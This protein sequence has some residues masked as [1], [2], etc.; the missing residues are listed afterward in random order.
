MIFRKLFQ[1]ISA[2][3][4]LTA[5]AF[6]EER[7]GLQ[8]IIDGTLRNQELSDTPPSA[9]TSQ[10]NLNGQ[11]VLLGS[12]RLRDDLS[13][14]Y[15]GRVNHTEDLSGS[16]PRV[17][18]TRTNSVVQAYV[19]YS[20]RLPWDL[21]LQIGKF[22]TPF[23]QF[24]TRNYSNENPLIGFPLTYTHRTPIRADQFPKSPYYLVSPRSDESSSGYLG[25]TD[26]D[27]RLPLLNFSYPTG[28][29]AFGNPGKFDYRIALV[30]SSLAN[31]LDLGTPGQRV[32]WIAA[33]GI[34]CV[35][36]LHLGASFAEGPYLDA[37]VNS[38][39][40]LGTS[41]NEFKQRALGFDFQYAIHHLEAYGE[42][43]FNTFEVPNIPQR[44]GAT[45]YYLELK[46]TWTPRFFSAIRWNQ[47]YFDRLR[48]GLSSDFR[49]RFDNNVNSLEFGLGYR[50]TERLLA[51]GSYQHNQ[52]LGGRDP[53]NDVFA[54]Q[55]VYSL[56]IWNLLRGR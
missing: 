16:S 37:S 30:N 11:F 17:Q 12:L 40:P 22:G 41:F 50:L 3:L 32:Q 45:G 48:G 5:S 14:F 52:N 21:N 55:I 26:S 4:C 13:A 15:E 10:T 8:G 49:P 35:V 25:G 20:P 29:M 28:I 24:L 53:Y 19:R 18:Q 56:D 23:G 43:L 54:L 39:L 1:L 33:G 7:F 36:G 34:N 31:P 46:Y 9:P 2:L 47:I 44:L 27:T 42:L 38:L 51:K 6:A